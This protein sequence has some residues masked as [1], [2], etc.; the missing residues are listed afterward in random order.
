MLLLYPDGSNSRADLQSEF[1]FH[2]ASTI[3][4]E[5]WHAEIREDIF[6]FH[7]A[8]TISLNQGSG[9]ARRLHLHSTLLLLYRS[10]LS[11]T[12]GCV[13]D[14]HSTMLLLYHST[15]ADKRAWV[16]DLH[17]TML[18]L[19]PEA[20]YAPNDINRIYIPLCFYYIGQSWSG[21]DNG[22]QIYIPL[23]FYYI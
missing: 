23:C 6:T 16:F 14:L 20:V 18:L 15:Y 22:Y 5:D 2:Y 13:S 9:T 21:W 17:S 7:Y 12:Q 4:E 19:Y 10:R 1:T 11:G 3:S 8:S